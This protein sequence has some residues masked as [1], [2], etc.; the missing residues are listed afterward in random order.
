MLGDGFE[1]STI[2]LTGPDGLNLGQAEESSGAGPEFHHEALAFTPL[3][4]AARLA[5]VSRR[6]GTITTRRD[7][8]A[9]P[10]RISSSGISSPMRRGPSL[11]GGLTYIPTWA[12]FL[13]PAVVLDARR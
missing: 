3:M 4:R 13:Y 1:Q 5:G 8:D 6:Q 2:L 12:G 7:H 9:G 11:R 10:L